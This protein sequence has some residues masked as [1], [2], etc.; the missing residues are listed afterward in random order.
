[1]Y[2]VWFRK[3][4][5]FNG[6]M[7][8]LSGFPRTSLPLNFSHPGRTDCRQTEKR[9]IKPRVLT[10]RPPVPRKSRIYPAHFEVFG[11][12]VGNLTFC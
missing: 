8:L 6:F 4:R 12:K 5:P 11:E 2:L 1:M 9:S 10:F 3:R 7:S